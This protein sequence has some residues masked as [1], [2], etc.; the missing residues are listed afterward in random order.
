M[1]KE[2]LVPDTSIFTNPDVYK[3]FGSNPSEAFTNFLLMVAELEGEIN[4]YLPSS[5]FEELKRMLNNLKLPPKARSVLKVKSPKKYE[6]YIPAFLMYEFIEE[7]RNRINKGLR[8][9][10]EAVKASTYKK[11]EEVLKF[12][13]R[14][15]REVLREGIVDSKEDL[16]IIL[17][18]LELDALVLS[19]D[20]GVLNM[21]DKLG[22]RY[23][24]PQDIKETLEGFKL[25]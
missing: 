16:E 11:P 6:L 4:V 13:R 24:E 22:L 25:W 5:V 18:A 21:A 9:A 14:R 2:R 1:E 20:K 7:L 10:E 19:A 8:V 3:Q 15:Y 12:L 17:L 23:L